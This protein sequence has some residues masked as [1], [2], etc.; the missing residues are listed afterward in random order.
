M[1]SLELN[2]SSESSFN[3]CVLGQ[4]KK[5]TEQAVGRKGTEGGDPTTAYFKDL[6][7]YQLLSVEEEQYYAKQVLLGDKDARKIMIESNLR[8]VVKMAKRY[9]NRGLSFLDLIEEGNVGLIRAVDKFDPYR[10]FRFSTYGVWWIQEGIEK[11]LMN[12]VRT[13]RLPVHVEKEL[14]ACLK[15]ARKLEVGSERKPKAQEIALLT[16]KPINKVLKT[17][18]LNERVTSVNA[19]IGKDYETSVLE[20]IPDNS[21]LSISELL[22]HSSIKGMLPNWLVQLS[23]RQQD[24]ICERYGVCGHT[25]KTLEELSHKYGVTRER[26]RQIQKDA[27]K[28]LNY[29]LN[30]TGFTGE[31]VL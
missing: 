26:I 13:I 9:L 17:M 25:P 10:G 22:D 11:A 3:E 15:A 28:K 23:D 1:M 24:I 19:S 20:M 14:Y 16:K 6:K 12:Q 18:A 27:L 7:Q 21:S 8:L 31:A 4:S 2:V 30:E 5:V 29:I